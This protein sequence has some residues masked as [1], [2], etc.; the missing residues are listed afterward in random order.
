M[1]VLDL[2]LERAMTVTELAERLNRPRGTVAYHVDILV[3]AGLLQVVRTRRVRA[4]DERYYGRTARTI[5]FHQQ[6]PGEMAFFSDVLAEADFE[7][8]EAKQPG[9]LRHAAPRPHPGR[10]APR[11]SPPGS[12]PCR[13]SSSPCRATAIS[14]SDCSSRLY[15]TTRLNAP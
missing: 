9:R 7:R 13:T 1:T 3:A 15:P 11:S 8:L 6:T 4:V 14:S 2:V 12:T 5:T 10:A